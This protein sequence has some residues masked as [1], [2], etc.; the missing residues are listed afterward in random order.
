M[1]TYTY[2]YTIIPKSIHDHHCLIPRARKDKK[3]LKNI[4]FLQG[5][6]ISVWS[7]EPEKIKKKLKNINFLQS[8]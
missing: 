4:N 5:P 6:T 7:H 8:P 1:Y 3:K 2:F